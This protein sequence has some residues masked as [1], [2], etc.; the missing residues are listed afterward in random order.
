MSN[1]G[2]LTG[3]LLEHGAFGHQTIG[4]QGITTMNSLWQQGRN[5]YSLWQQGK[6]VPL[7]VASLLIV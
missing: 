4:D 5:I 6:M 2:G 7:N 1:D 3:S